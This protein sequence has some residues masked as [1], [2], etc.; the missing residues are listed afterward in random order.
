MQ[1]MGCVRLRSL[2]P[3]TR[4]RVF[5]NIGL[6]PHRAP[7][8]IHRLLQP[9]LLGEEEKEEALGRGGGP[10]PALHRL[11]FAATHSLGAFGEGF[12]SSHDMTD[13][14]GEVAEES[15]RASKHDHMRRCIH[16]RTL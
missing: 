2:L 13:S 16:Q 9:T 7:K 6:V 15:E 10:A 11:P 1:N 14:S 8:P 12:V 5:N 3:T 4:H